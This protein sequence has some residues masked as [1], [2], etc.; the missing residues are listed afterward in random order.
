VCVFVARASV[1]IPVITSAHPY[2]DLYPYTH[3]PALSSSLP[4]NVSRS[5]SQSISLSSPLPPSPS[6]CRCQCPREEPLVAEQ[7]LVYILCTEAEWPL[8]FWQPVRQSKNKGRTLKMNTLQ[9][10]TTEKCKGVCVCVCV[11]GMDLRTG[12]KQGLAKGLR[13]THTLASTHT[14]T[15]GP[16]DWRQEGLA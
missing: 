9:M 2:L 12:D 7:P 4:V 11:C 5:P 10:N 8:Y 13:H 14:H 16:Q 3:S 6:P 1:C 15:H